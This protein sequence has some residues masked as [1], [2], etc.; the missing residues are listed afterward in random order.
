MRRSMRILLLAATLGGLLSLGAIGE[1]APPP[2]CSQNP[3]GEC[4][5]RWN[6]D[7]GVSSSLLKIVVKDIAPNN[8]AAQHV[9]VRVCD[10]GVLDD[11]FRLTVIRTATPKD[12]LAC[13]TFTGDSIGCSVVAAKAPSSASDTVFAIIQEVIGGAGD[14]VDGAFVQI[15]APGWETLK[16]YVEDNQNASVSATTD[17]CP[18]VGP[19]SGR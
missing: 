3:P 7:G 17:D 9:K 6:N 11:R 8:P 13:H 16:V 19:A 18:D 15:S 5:L 12:I 2:I 1:A 10:T 4:R 14:D